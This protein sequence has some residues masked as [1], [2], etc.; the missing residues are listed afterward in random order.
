MRLVESFPTVLVSSSEVFSIETYDHIE[1]EPH[2]QP[3]MSLNSIESYEEIKPSVAIR[4][5]GV[6]LVIPATLFYK[7]LGWFESVL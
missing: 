6:L 5:K 2:N 7:V 4:P 3:S 1:P